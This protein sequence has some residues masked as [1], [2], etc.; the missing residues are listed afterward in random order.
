MIWVSSPRS[1]RVWG[2]NFTD[3]FSGQSLQWNLKGLLENCR[4]RLKAHTGRFSGKK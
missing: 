1:I 3:D 4:D 2:D